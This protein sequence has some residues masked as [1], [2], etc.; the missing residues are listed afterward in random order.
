MAVVAFPNRARHRCA[1]GVDA[2]ARSTMSGRF[3]TGKVWIGIGRRLVCL[4]GFDGSDAA[5]VGAAGHC[6]RI[7]GGCQRPGFAEDAGSMAGE[8]P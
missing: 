8:H 3:K 1:G 7:S 2:E 5:R 4:A 6:R